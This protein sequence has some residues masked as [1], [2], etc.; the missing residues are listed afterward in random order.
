MSDFCR[1]LVNFT[2]E[3]LLSNRAKLMS[4][5]NRRHI[6]MCENFK[7][8]RIKKSIQVAIKICAKRNNIF[9]N[10]YKREVCKVN[11]N[12]NRSVNQQKEKDRDRNN[13]KEEEICLLDTLRRHGRSVNI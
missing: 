13:H 10:L 4:N 7:P 1:K 6:V 5:L 8:I 9:T 2:F 11:S 3:L 12:K